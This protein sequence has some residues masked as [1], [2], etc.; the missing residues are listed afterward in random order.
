MIEN[1]LDVKNKPM[2]YYFIFFQLFSFCKIFAKFNLLNKEQINRICSIN[3]EII[4]NFSIERKLMP[5]SS[6]KKDEESK[7]ELLGK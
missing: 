7:Y 6:N 1:S 5:K 4:L 3:E 2:S